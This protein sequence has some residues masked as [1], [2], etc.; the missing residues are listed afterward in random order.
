MLGSS[1]TTAGTSR[2]APSSFFPYRQYVLLPF[3]TTTVEI[4]KV[5]ERSGNIYENKGPAF[6]SPMESG[7]VFENTGT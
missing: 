5:S 1:V 3:A 6:H 4:Q 7:N 2:M